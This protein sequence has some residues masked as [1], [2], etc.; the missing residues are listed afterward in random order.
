MEWLISRFHLKHF[1]GTS[2]PQKVS[3]G[4][5]GYALKGSLTKE[6]NKASEDKAFWVLTN[7]GKFTWAKSGSHQ[8]PY[9]WVV[10]APTGSEAKS[11]ALYTLGEDMFDDATGIDAVV[12]VNDNEPIYTISGVKVANSKAL[13]PG[14]Y[15]KGG[16]KFTVS[17]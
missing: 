2:E 17:K 7:G 6:H 12:V 4:S 14:M 16:K 13:A 11:F 9:H 10:Y 8:R 3:K 5:E 15:I 1:K